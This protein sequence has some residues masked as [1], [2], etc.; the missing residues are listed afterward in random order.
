MI[1][2]IILLAVAVMLLFTLFVFFQGLPDSRSSPGKRVRWV[3]VA[4]SVSV[5]AALG[6]AVT[7]QVQEKTGKVIA[8]SGGTESDARAWLS[9]HAAEQPSANQPGDNIRILREGLAFLRSH[10]TVAMTPEANRII[11]TYSAL[12][13]RPTRLLTRQEE[14]QYFEGA[15]AVY[16]VINAVAGSSET[17]PADGV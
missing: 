8:L 17:A 4:L 14:I 12:P 3:M 2:I 5:V 16:Q 9:A 11:T 15:K 7:I 10:P 6:L 13:E 1:F